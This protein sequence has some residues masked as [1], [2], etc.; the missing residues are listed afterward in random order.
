[1]SMQQP[2]SYRLGQHTLELAEEE[3]ITIGNE[4]IAVQLEREEAY[5]LHLVLADLFHHLDH[6]ANT[7]ITHTSD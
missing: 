4:T 7:E 6:L 3:A 1:M 2:T 5:R